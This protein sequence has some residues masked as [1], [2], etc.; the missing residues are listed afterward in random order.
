MHS[1]LFL[2]P[3]KPRPKTA[4][5][6]G[7]KVQENEHMPNWVVDRWKEHN[8]IITQSINSQHNLNDDDINNLN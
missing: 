5:K 3:S 4:L 6:H 8:Y 2:S 1:P 7:E